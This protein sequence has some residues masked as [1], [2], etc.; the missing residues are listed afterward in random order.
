MYLMQYSHLQLSVMSAY[1]MKSLISDSVEKG[2][3]AYNIEVFLNSDIFWSW[4]QEAVKLGD[5]EQQT[6]DYS[7]GDRRL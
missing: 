2:N 4:M 1:N 5:E 7:T 6:G 3:H